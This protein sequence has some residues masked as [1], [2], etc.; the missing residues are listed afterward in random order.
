MA[1]CESHKLEVGGSIPSPASCILARHRLS[2]GRSRPSFQLRSQCGP[3]LCGIDGTPRPVRDPAG[4][5]L[6]GRLT[7]LRVEKLWG[8]DDPLFPATF[9][10]PGSARQFEAIG[11]SRNHW[12]GAARIREIFRDAFPG[13][14]LQY[15][16]PHSLRNTLLPL[17]EAR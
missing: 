2:A 1:A 6:A 5:V 14:G 15:F 17:G 10:K 3:G 16:N 12:Q 4:W 9:V 7:Y 8:N 11:L 13:A